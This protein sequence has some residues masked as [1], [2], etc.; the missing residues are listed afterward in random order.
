M[1]YYNKEE[2]FDPEQHIN[3]WHALMHGKKKKKEEKKP[4]DEDDKKDD[5]PPSEPN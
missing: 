5:D 1:I 2:D 3:N 4:A